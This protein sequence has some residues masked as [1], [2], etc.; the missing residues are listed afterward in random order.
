MIYVKL[1]IIFIE[2]NKHCFENGTF[3]L[4]YPANLSGGKELKKLVDQKLRVAVVEREVFAQQ[5]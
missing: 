3:L 4:H 2:S 5:L 1:R